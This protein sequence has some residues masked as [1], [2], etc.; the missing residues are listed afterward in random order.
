MPHRLPGSVALPGPITVLFVL[1]AGLANVSIMLL[2]GCGNPIVE[3]NPRSDLPPGT[4]VQPPEQ[5]RQI[6]PDADELP[7]VLKLSWRNLAANAPFASALV[8]WDGKA[9]ATK[10]CVVR[11]PRPRSTRKGR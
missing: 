7:N 2:A 1:L 3:A 8:E 9:S 11:P 5:S 6:D 4:A 10:R